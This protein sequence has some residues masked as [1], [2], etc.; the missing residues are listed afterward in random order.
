MRIRATVDVR[1]VLTNV[2]FPGTQQQ[3]RA[4]SGQGFIPRQLDISFQ[5][6]SGA[7]LRPNHPGERGAA[8]EA[9]TRS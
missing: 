7:A 1:Q 6:R 8:G 5:G 9:Q 4:T 2:C 3:A